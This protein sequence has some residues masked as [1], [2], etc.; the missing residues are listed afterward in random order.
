M[1]KKCS[2]TP[3]LPVNSSPEFSQVFYKAQGTGHTLQSRVSS[4]TGAHFTRALI[5]APAQL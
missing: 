3:E 2:K 1:A 5:W 4:W